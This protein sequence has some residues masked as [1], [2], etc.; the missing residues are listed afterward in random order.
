LKALL[1]SDSA[2]SSVH[3]DIWMPLPGAGWPMS[4]GKVESKN[5]KA[6]NNFK[7]FAS[8][9]NGVCSNLYEKCCTGTC[10]P[11]AGDFCKKTAADAYGI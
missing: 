11:L 7:T 5:R 10:E 3:G 9:Q 2:I 8:F 1:V 4:S 6:M